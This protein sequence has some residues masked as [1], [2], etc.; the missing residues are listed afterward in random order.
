MMDDALVNYMRTAGDLARFRQS[1]AFC[2]VASGAFMRPEAPS[3]QILP[4]RVS[5]ELQA[6]RNGMFRL[7][8]MIHER[9]ERGSSAQT[10]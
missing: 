1:S 7:E 8:T 3:D 9:A 5:D 10:Q 6:V 4:K 2:P